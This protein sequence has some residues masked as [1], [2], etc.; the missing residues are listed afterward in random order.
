VEEVPAAHSGLVQQ[1]F[2]LQ[3]E[4]HREATVQHLHRVA[5]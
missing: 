1:E 5:S 2:K 4:G 3:V